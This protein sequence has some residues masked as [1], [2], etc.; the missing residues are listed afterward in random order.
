[1]P[2]RASLQRLKQSLL[3]KVA[4]TTAFIT[5]FFIAYF[6]VLRHPVFEVTPM[7]E[8][9]LDRLIGFQPAALLP[10]VSLWLYV[11]IPPALLYGL[12][13]LVAYGCWIAALCIAG[14]ACFY[15]WPT[16]IPPILI[17]TTQYPGFAVIQGL[18]AAGNACPSLHVATAA[19]SAIWLDRLLGEIG[20]ARTVRA[21]NWLWFALIA[22]ST[23]AIKQHVALDVLAGLLLGLSFAL[24]SLRLRPASL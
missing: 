8:T 10:Y 21:G 12:R 3:L 18:D 7:P 23:L 15:F 22:W 11:G 4:G 14:L 17:D 20:A 5:L 16:A 19:F 6:H 13:E 2:W 24:P 1:M 9:A